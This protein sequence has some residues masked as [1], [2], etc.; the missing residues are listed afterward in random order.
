MQMYNNFLESMRGLK[1]TRK[2]V[3]CA[4][5]VALHTA[6][7][8]LAAIQIGDTIRISFGYLS[9]AANAVLLGPFPAM[10]GAMISDLL[11]CII[12]PTG[13]FFPGFTISAGLGGLIYGVI[14]YKREM[15]LWRVLLAKMLIDVCVNILLNTLWLKMLYGNGYFV[16]LPLRAF[17]NLLQYPVDV[18]LLYP[19]MR[20]CAT[21]KLRMHL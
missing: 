1:E 7:N 16:M 14:L 2:L 11:G 20:W 8:A 15:C 17:K 21:M 12:K 10:I 5:L 19:A 4:L 13:A 9:V 3:Y 6:L 18:L